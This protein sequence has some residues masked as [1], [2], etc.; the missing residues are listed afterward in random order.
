MAI[1]ECLLQLAFTCSASSMPSMETAVLCMDITSAIQQKVDNVILLP[2]AIEPHP[3]A[4]SKPL[5]HLKCVYVCVSGAEW[6]VD[7]L[8]KQ[9]GGQGVGVDSRERQRSIK[10]VGS[11]QAAKQIADS[12][13]LLAK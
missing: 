8:G 2:K 11:V 1:S 12:V 5:N 13:F 9:T 6:W 7:I 4:R 3:S 10:G